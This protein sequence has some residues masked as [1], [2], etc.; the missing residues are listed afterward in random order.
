MPT[1]RKKRGEDEWH[2]CKNCSNW[3]MSDYDEEYHSGTERPSTGELCNGGLTKQHK[4][5]LSGYNGK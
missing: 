2:W 1:Y 3:P 4:W 5:L